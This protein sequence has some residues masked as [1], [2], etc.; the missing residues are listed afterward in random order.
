MKGKMFVL[1]DHGTGIQ[2]RLSNPQDTI[3]W[4]IIYVS[5]L[6]NENIIERYA[7]LTTILNLLNMWEEKC[8]II[9]KMVCICNPDI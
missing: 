5:P 7:T 8:G 2:L 9:E 6:G 4:R 1:K 3:Y